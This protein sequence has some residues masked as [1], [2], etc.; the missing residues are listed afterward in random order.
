MKH[1]GD[2]TP[3]SASDVLADRGYKRVLA[4][5][6]PP[7]NGQIV[8]TLV[9]MHCGSETYW[10]MTSPALK[11]NDPMTWQGVVPVVETRTTYRPAP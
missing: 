2:P 7:I 3:R 8:N 10:M 9:G 5:Q 4:E 1:P 6:A 11:P